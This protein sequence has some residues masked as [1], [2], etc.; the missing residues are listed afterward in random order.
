MQPSQETLENQHLDLESE[1]EA[2]ENQKFQPSP[3]HLELLPLDENL[4]EI[5]GFS[6]ATPHETWDGLGVGA[7]KLTIPTLLANGAGTRP[8]HPIGK[9]LFHPEIQW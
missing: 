2:Q 7:D 6:T 1:A 9:A 3:R 8:D 4:V 5:L